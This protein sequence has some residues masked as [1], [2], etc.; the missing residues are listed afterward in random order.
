M[1][2]RA[3]LGYRQIGER[4]GISPGLAHSLKGEHDRAGMTL[5]QRV[6][7]GLRNGGEQA[8]LS[9]YD[10]LTGARSGGSN[11]GQQL[12]QCPGRRLQDAWSWL[13]DHDMGALMLMDALNVVPIPRGELLVY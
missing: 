4:L 1:L 7:Q 6:Q 8:W 12:G 13:F 10:V 9:G 5:Y 2:F 3:G 11:H